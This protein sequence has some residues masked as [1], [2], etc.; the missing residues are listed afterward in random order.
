MDTNGSPSVQPILSRLFEPPD[1]VARSTTRNADYAMAPSSLTGASRG[2]RERRPC[3]WITKGPT[4]LA[5]RHV[6][7]EPNPSAIGLM[8]APAPNF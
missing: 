6:A 8:G 1:R 2:T 7:T 3:T 4:V 5:G